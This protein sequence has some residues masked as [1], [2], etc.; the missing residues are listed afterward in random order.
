MKKCEF[1]GLI[2]LRREKVGE[3]DGI[4]WIENKNN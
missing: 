3:S 4:L 2:N 1:H